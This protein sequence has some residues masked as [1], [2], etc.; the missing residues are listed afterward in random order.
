MPTCW[1]GLWSVQSQRLTVRLICN[2]IH[3]LIVRTDSSAP[4]GDRNARLFR[5]LVVI[6]CVVLGGYLLNNLV[7][8]FFIK[9]F[10]LNDVQA[11]FCGTY[12]GAILNIGASAEVPI[13]FIFRWGVSLSNVGNEQYAS[14]VRIIGNYLIM[15]GS[16]LQE[17]NRAA[18]NYSQH[19]PKQTMLFRLKSFQEGEVKL[20]GSLR[21]QIPCEQSQ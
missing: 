17:R 18:S 4:A 11:W 13:L 2:P 12:S 7:R 6:I 16:D 3:L 1:F 5:S 14:S 21:S 10:A 9:I 15:N 20:E 19:M 8:L